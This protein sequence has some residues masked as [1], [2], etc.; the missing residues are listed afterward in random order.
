MEK[1]RRQR[2]KHQEEVIASVVAELKADVSMCK[3]PHAAAKLARYL[4][5]CTVARWL[6][7]LTLHLAVDI[8]GCIIICV[9]L[10][11][12]EEC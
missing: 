4:V 1:Q 3:D 10:F 5:G 6:R 9:V 11:F 2:L 12:A 8:L 7:S